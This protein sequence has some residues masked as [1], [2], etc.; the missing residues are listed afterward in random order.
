MFVKGSEVSIPMRSVIN[1]CSITSVIGIVLSCYCL[2]QWNRMDGN[3]FNAPSA[4]QIIGFQCTNPHCGKVFTNIFTYDQHRNHATRAWTLCASIMMREKLTAVHR[5]DRSSAV[6]SAR[7]HR[8]NER[9]AC[10]K[11]D[12]HRR[13][14]SAEMF[15]R[16]P[17]QKFR[18][19]Q[20]TLRPCSKFVKILLNSSECFS[21]FK[22]HLGFLRSC[23]EFKELRDINMYLDIFRYF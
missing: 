11:R 9:D 2:S 10:T 5:A 16:D 7:P 13:M 15:T 19:I 1:I 14:S 3:A 23:S 22:H 6:L 4:R 21:S 18:R 12:A 20:H 8:S 17:R